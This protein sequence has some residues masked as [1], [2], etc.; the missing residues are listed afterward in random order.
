MKVSKNFS[1]GEPITDL[2]EIKRLALERK[3]VIIY[4]G[5]A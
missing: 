5:G 2:R 1:K 3:S 4:V